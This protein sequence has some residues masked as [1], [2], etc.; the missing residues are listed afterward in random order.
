M[1]K[2]SFVA[3]ECNVIVTAK[4]KTEAIQKVLESGAK[5]AEKASAKSVFLYN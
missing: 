3:T 1:K 2:F 4:N 5:G